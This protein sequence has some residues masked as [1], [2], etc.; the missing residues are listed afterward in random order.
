MHGQVKGGASYIE[1]QKYAEAK[2]KKKKEEA[3]ALLASL[4][5]NAQGLAGK[6][7]EE[8]TSG[9]QAINLYKDPR[10]GSENMPQDTI[11]TCKNFLD[12][13]EDEKYGWR[14][15][16]PQGGVK[17]Q[18]RHMLPEGYIVTSKKEREKDRKA[19]ELAD[20]D[21]ET[22]EEKIEKERAALSSEGL[23][24]VTKDSFFEWKAR[25]KEQKQKALEDQMKSE[26]MKAAQG[27]ATKKAHK[28]VMNGRALF[29]YNPDLF[30]DDDIVEE[31]KEEAKVDEN[32]FAEEEAGAE[33]DEIDFD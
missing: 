12:A 26:E 23:T 27:R 17:C 21:E 7:G 28:G 31:A 14:W 22:L 25:R 10:E 9:T 8:L 4:F 19:R 2:D 33:E 6:K 16:C 24:P 29:T 3:N 30:K 18:Y 5:K 20:A 1:Q 13:V 15:E 11:I 32:L